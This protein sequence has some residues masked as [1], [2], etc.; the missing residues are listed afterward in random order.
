VVGKDHYDVA[1]QVQAILQRYKDLQDIIAILGMD[2]LSEED[3]KAVNRARRIR[4]FLSQPFHVAEK[5][6]GFPGKYVPV[7][8]TVHSFKAILDGEGDYLP[9]DAFTYVGTFEEAK[10]KGD[11]ILAKANADA[12]KKKEAATQA[13]N[14]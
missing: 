2:E 7:S 12:A 8:D 6:N 9:E 4:N 5:F 13:V 3:K 1:R 11:A 14:K 10:A